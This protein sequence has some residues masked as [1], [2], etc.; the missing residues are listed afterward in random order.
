M[1]ARSA[2]KKTARPAAPRG[3]PK[4]TVPPA[5]AEAA[6][7]D[8]RLRQALAEVPKAAD[9]QPLAD[10]LYTFAQHAPALLQS[11]QQITAPLREICD[12]LQALQGSLSEALLRMPRPEEYEPLAGPLREF[13]RVSPAL[14]ESLSGLPRLAGVLAAA[15]ERLERVSERIDTPAG[16]A[17]RPT[18]ASPSAGTLASRLQDV[19]GELEEARRGLLGALGTLPREDDY[20][21]VARQLRELASVS[22]S[23]LEWMKEVPKVSAPLGDSVAALRE[24]VERVGTA[25]A[26]V[27]A[28]IEGLSA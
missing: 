19:A 9:F 24:A 22:P 6:A 15:A 7:T 18:P 14:A 1:P 3:R 12:N 25:R 21:P 27:L 23:L 11:M 20:A 16:G 10:H 26:A 2:K 8:E 5:T 13:A 4:A 28:A 17:P